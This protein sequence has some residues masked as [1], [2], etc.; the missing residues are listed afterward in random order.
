MTSD[1]IMHVAVGVIRNNKNQVLL[2]RRSAT[3]HQPDLWE[4]PGGKLETGETVSE[5]LSRELHEE[6]ALTVKSAQPL[7]QIHHDYHEYSVLLDVWNVDSWDL[8]SFD[9]NERVGK[10]GQIIEW[11]DIQKLDERDYPEANKPIIKAV[12]LPKFY[13]ICPDPEGNL[14]EYL[15]KFE[16]CISAGVTL[17]QL[18]FS[19]DSHYERYKFLISEL[20]EL[21]R[22]NHAILMINSSPE[23][24]IKLGANGV[25][26][27]S[28]RLL[29][30]NKRPLDDNYLVS[31]SCHNYSELE[32]AANID[33]DFLVLSP[34]NRTASH[35]TAEPL[36][37]EKFKTL[38]EP[39]PVPTYALGGMQADDMKKSCESG[40]Q[41][42]SV[43]SGIWNQKS[44]KDTVL[45][46][47]Q[48]T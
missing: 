44:T 29:Q 4:F 5:A 24:A 21:C 8:N 43:L 13:L 36:G 34:V 33:V 35:P 32:H 7:I 47:F 11:V 42:I 18:R 27:N 16:E 31:A 23:Y 39:I 38:V 37:W 14:K 45:K 1:V 2:S 15:K 26:L 6:L 40:G 48:G 19:D 46:Y 17:F 30:Q 3:V 25:H 12:K 41:G 28:T 10:E 22:N 9:V 20:L